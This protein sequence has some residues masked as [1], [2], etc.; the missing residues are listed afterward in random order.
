MFSRRSRRRT[1]RAS[2][3]RVPPTCAFPRSSPSDALASAPPSHRRI[4]RRCVRST[5]FPFARRSPNNGT[6]TASAAAAAVPATASSRPLQQQQSR[7]Q[8]LRVRNGSSRRYPARSRLRSCSFHATHV[9]TARN[10]ASLSPCS[11]SGAPHLQPQHQHARHCA[12]TLAAPFRCL[13]AGRAATTHCRHHA[14]AARHRHT[15][16]NSNRTDSEFA[17]TP[18][19]RLQ[20]SASATS[21]CIATSPS[22]LHPL[23]RRLRCALLR[24]SP[25]AAPT[26]PSRHCHCPA[27]IRQLSTLP[28]RHPGHWGPHHP[29]VDA[30]IAQSLSLPFRSVSVAVAVASPWANQRISVS[31]YPR[32]RVS[33]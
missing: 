24:T 3:R 8:R 9:S 7:H 15:I 14:A 5:R 31:A 19:T 23:P 18:L 12:S 28:S 2:L 11:S 22:R 30:A 17:P 33:A 4:H 29:C 25:P 26:S 27:S 21:V 1:S 13:C 6:C 10:S 32:I 16:S 20:V